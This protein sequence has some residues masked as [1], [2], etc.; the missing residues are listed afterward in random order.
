VQGQLTVPEI[1]SFAIILPN[2]ETFKNYQKI[3]FTF[4]NHIESIKQENKKLEELQLIILS[5]LSTIEN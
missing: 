4:T 5:K 3:S 2:S 1:S